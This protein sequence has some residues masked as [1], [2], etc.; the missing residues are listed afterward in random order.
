MALNFA[1]VLVFLLAAL[2]L[3]FA[4]MTL[5]KVFR[6]HKPINFAEAAKILAKAHGIANDSPDSN[7]EWFTPF[8]EALNARGAM[9]S[10]SP[11]A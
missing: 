3:V 9:P 7:V 4:H 10:V 1:T 5:S 2:F 11:D 8:I 6:P